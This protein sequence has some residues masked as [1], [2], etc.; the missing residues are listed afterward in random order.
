M[1]PGESDLRIFKDGNKIVFINTLF[2]EIDI[3]IDLE[4][5]RCTYTCILCLYIYTSILR[6][7]ALCLRECKLKRLRVITI[8]FDLKD[9]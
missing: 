5:C 2:I 4:I 9:E 6:T 7:Y 1:V 3:T 8:H